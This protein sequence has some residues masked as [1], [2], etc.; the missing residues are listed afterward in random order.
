GVV[1]AGGDVIFLDE[2]RAS[3]TLQDARSRYRDLQLH[4]NYLAEASPFSLQQ[5][6]AHAN[7][8]SALRRATFKLS[9]VS[10]WWWLLLALVSI[11]E[12][13][14]L[15]TTW[16]EER[17]ARIHAEM[18]AQQPEQDATALWKRAIGAWATT[19]KSVGEPGIAL[20]L[21]QVA[22]VPIE[23]GRWRLI[24]VDCR[25]G[26]GVCTAKYRRTR[27][28]DNNTLDSALPEGWMVAHAD[29]ESASASWQLPPNLAAHSLKL[30]ELPS[31]QE[32]RTNW[33]PSWQA[34]RPALQDFT[35]GP[36]TQATVSVPNIKLPNG[37]EQPVPMPK[38]ITLPASRSLVI[39]APLRSFY[40]LVLPPTSEISQ[41][42]LRYTPDV[43]PGLTASAFSATLKGIIHV[44][45]P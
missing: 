39:N 10:P 35:L 17:Q 42:Q 12:V 11:Y 4:S 26:Q 5:L 41:L 21:D 14:D 3:E 18:K 19:V 16:W 28:A 38:G 40:G 27:L 8:Q 2:A 34:L 44:Q 6:T 45:S 37:L 43:T 32:I 1:Q 33:E 30:S 24:E 20:L 36:A 13:W 25:P 29:L 9:M 22:R 15:G 7:P 31:A 23:P